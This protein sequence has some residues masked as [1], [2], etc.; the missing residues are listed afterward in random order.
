MKLKTY[1]H[2]KNKKIFNRNYNSYS[3][4]NIINIYIKVKTN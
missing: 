3:N 1:N 2:E 4:N